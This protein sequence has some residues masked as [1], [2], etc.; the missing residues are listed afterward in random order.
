MSIL[1]RKLDFKEICDINW[2][3]SVD[4]PYVGAI[5]TSALRRAFSKLCE[6]NPIL[7]SRIYHKDSGF[8]I[9]ANGK[10]RPTL[11]VVASD[12]VALDDVVNEPPSCE[13]GVVA[14]TLIQG[15]NHGHVVLQAN[16][17]VF[18][19][20]RIVSLVTDLWR[21]YTG[22][23]KNHPVPI[24]VYKSLPPPPSEFLRN[25][26]SGEAAG[27]MEVSPSLEQLCKLPVHT[28]TKTMQLTADETRT[29]IDLAKRVGIS[30]HGMLA[31]VILTAIHSC[32]SNVATSRILCGSPVDLRR[33]AS[34][35]L[36]PNA[37]SRFSGHFN[38]VVSV[39][40]SESPLEI[41]KKFAKK[42]KKSV[43][44]GSRASFLAG[45]IRTSRRPD[46]DCS[47]IIS[48]LGIIPDFS[49]PEHLQLE[50]FFVYNP[51]HW[52]VFVP[53]AERPRRAVSGVR[54]ARNCGTFGINTHEGRM[55]ISLISLVDANFS[56]GRPQLLFDVIRDKLRNL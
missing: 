16:H 37:S 45:S 39:D 47:V 36:S 10:H 4:M 9:I 40:S 12:D 14:L 20:S 35:Q 52:S 2:T 42:L 56:E 18:D 1:E 13:D 29:L 32:R 31:G 30:V 41:G 11:T 23:I 48:N 27:W 26:Y 25:S 22:I 8:Y 55:S 54:A 6:Y 44:E 3:P 19:G 15:D 21:V 38:T 7:N 5:N 49:T 17:G 46:Y 33:D 43:S 28:K 51:E 53:G 24:E 50:G 34:V